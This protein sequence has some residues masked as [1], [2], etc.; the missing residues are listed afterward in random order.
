[1]LIS[2]L[3]H[4]LQAHKGGMDYDSPES[5]YYVPASQEHELYSQ[6]RQEKIRAI[7]KDEIE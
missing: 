5:P 3:L 2:P 1:M 7:V 4:P 6:L